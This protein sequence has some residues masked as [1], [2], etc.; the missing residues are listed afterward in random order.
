MFNFGTSFITKLP[1]I[2]KT[3]YKKKYYQLLYIIYFNGGV[4]CLLLYS[5]DIQAKLKENNLI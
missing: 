3:N 5:E 1:V 2:L 4:K